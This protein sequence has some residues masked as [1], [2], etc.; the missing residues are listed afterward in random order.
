MKTVTFIVSKGGVGKT[1]V[2]ANV[3]YALAKKNQKVVLLEGDP[4]QP[5]QKIFDTPISAKDPKLDDIIK[6]DKPISEAIYPTKTE[7]LLLLPSGVSLQNYFE[8]DPISFAQKISDLKT[9]YIFI[10]VPF[11][12]G[13]AA[14][15]SLGICQYFIPILTEDEFVLCVESTIDTIRLSKYLLKSTPLGFVLNRI[16]TPTTFSKEFT[17][18]L[19]NLLGIPC[20]TRINEDPKV[21]KSYGQVGSEKAFLAC[22][23]LSESEFAKGID[24]IA[25]RLMGKLPESEKDAIRLLQQ[26]T[27]LSLI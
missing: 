25:T 9:D 20:I 2:T 6:K 24:Q 14:L 5:L 17:A 19:E 26:I 3:G 12:L 21:S 1:L 15:L 16:K 18:D 23:K 4:N 22:E 10:D 11:P 27:R 13:K 8:I 7:N